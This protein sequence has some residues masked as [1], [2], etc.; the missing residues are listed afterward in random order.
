MP[1]KFAVKIVRL[2]IYNYDYCQSDDLDLHSRSQKR[3]KLLLV[4]NLQYLSQYFSYYIQQLGTPVLICMAHIYIY[5]Y[6][7]ARF[8]VFDL[9]FEIVCKACPSYS[10]SLSVSHSRPDMTFRG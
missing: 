2:K 10:V 8:V 1:I 3:L 9:D 4:F 5:I 7:Y 6:V